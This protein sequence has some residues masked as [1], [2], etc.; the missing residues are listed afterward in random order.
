MGLSRL[1]PVGEGTAAKA[2]ALEKSISDELLLLHSNILNINYSSNSNIDSINIKETGKGK[3]GVN[4][5]DYPSTSNS[6]GQDNVGQILLTLLSFKKLKQENPEKD[7]GGILLI[8]ELDATVH[9]AAQKKLF[10][11]LYK[12][13]LELDLQIVF[14]THSLSL[15]NHVIDTKNST[16]DKN[17]KVK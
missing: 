7:N 5:I 1:Y 4:T 10:D 14:T 11:Y 16:K 9:P 15:I 12:T 8:D 13:S 3:S 17:I 2:T 6:S